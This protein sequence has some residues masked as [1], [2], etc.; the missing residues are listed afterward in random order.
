MRASRSRLLIAAAALL[1]LCAGPAWGQSVK[2]IKDEILHKHRDGMARYDNFEFE[3]ARKLLEAAVALAVDNGLDAEPLLARVYLDLGVI[4][5]SGLQDANGAELQFIKAVE[6]DP[7]IEL[8]PAYSAPAMEELLV[9]VKRRF[10]A[11]V[12]DTDAP[13]PVD[14]AAIA[15]VEHT[16]IDAA[17]A[18]KDRWVD[19]HVSGRLGADQVK[20]HYRP[21]GVADASPEFTAV[22]MDR[23][24]GCTFA[25]R[26]P[27]PMI[28]GT[29]VHYYIAAYNK[30][31]RVIAS[32]GSALTP[33]LMVVEAGEE[34]ED[35]NPLAPAVPAATG[36]APAPGR[37][38]LAVALGTGGGYISGETEQSRTAINCCF[39]P[40]LLHLRL[41]AGYR[42]M[43]RTS[44]SLALRLGFPIG[45]STM[46]HATLAPAVLVRLRQE[47]DLAGLSVVG[48][49]GGGV[50]RQTIQIE[51]GVAGMDVDTAAVGPVLLGGGLG[52]AR[53][54]GSGLRLVAEAG[55]L[56]GVPV[57]SELGSTRP[58]LGVHLDLDVGLALAF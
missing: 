20:L 13:A 27:G 44:L 21:H 43:P 1:A 34:A 55:L 36:P 35:E 38:H 8:D 57:V 48:A 54:L 22:T 56:V 46:D 30:G 17:E 29:V 11:G 3:D 10:G 12:V 41:E 16:L 45:A 2:R 51:N 24:A 33:N 25:A 5:F 42:M 39:A 47:L 9:R 58:E 53:P 52:Y 15:G 14:C 50:I 23:R 26:I 6:V 19:A 28:R 4:Y 40:E 7:R 49:L 18:G 31:G 32:H 37:V